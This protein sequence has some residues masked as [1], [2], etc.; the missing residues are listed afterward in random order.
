M[1]DGQGT[2]ARNFLKRK[3][4]SLLGVSAAALMA[5]WV[6]P[7]PLTPKFGVLDATGL[8]DPS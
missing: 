7:R 4:A 6:P 5:V 8:G 1:P 2:Y 3:M